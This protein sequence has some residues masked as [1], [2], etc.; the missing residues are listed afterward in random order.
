MLNI[1]L[2]I[3]LLLSHNALLE[4]STVMLFMCLHKTGEI[5][6]GIST[7]IKESRQ[8]N[9]LCLTSFHF[10]IHLNSFACSISMHSLVIWYSVF[11][12]RVLDNFRA[13]KQRI[14]AR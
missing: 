5:K 7:K 9:R 2:I 14:R 11:F 3:C 8:Q 10:I 13:L 12:T 1:I 4:I 6:H